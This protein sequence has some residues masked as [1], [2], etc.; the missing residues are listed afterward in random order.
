MSSEPASPSSISSDEEIITRTMGD[1]VKDYNTEEL[2]EYLR[3]KNLKLNEAHFEIF[4]QEEISGI[5]FLE[6]TKDDFI[7]FGFKGGPSIILAKFVE[8]LKE[9]K[10]RSFSSYKT[11][12]ELKELPREYKVNGDNITY[13]KQFIPIFE[14]I[15]DDDEALKQCFSEITLRLSQIK[16][17]TDA[18]EATRRTFIESILHASIAI[19]RRRTNKEIDIEYQREVSGEESTGRVDFAISGIEDLLCITE[20]KPRNIKIGYLQNIKQLESSFHTNKKRTADQ[21][22][23]NDGYDYLYGIVSTGVDWH[24]IMFTSDGLY[25]TS[26]SE[27]QIDLTKKVIRENQEILRNNIK[28]IIGII[29]GLLKDRV[30]VC[31]KPESKRRRVQEKIK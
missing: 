2:I 11:V 20:G 22:F 6:L 25:C 21:A 26:K 23:N 13:I 16:S 8:E 12:E 28:E 31:D 17:M 4:R 1:V 9:Q 18:N 10:L 7:N 15:D 3:R 27:Y 30:T 19:A 5:S 24:F 29:V 14:K